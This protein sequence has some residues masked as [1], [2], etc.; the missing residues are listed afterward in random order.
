M[1][2]ITGSAHA[3]DNPFPHTTQTTTQRNMAVVTYSMGDFVRPKSWR[4]NK[5]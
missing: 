4:R 3:G 1:E 2:E 5:E